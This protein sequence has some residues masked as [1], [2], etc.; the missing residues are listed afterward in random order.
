MPR[1]LVCVGLAPKK[2][3]SPKSFI[4]TYV[5]TESI[6]YKYIMIHTFWINL[7]HEN[8]TFLVILASYHIYNTYRYN[9]LL[10]LYN[11]H[12]MQIKQVMNFRHST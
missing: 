9:Y 5:Q 8:P 2:L 3:F 6:G 4:F 7:Q 11:N 1:L 10:H 12:S